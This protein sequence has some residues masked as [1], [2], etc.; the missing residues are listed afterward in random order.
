V[1]HGTHLHI[2][3]KIDSKKLDSKVED[4]ASTYTFVWEKGR[5]KQY[6][7]CCIFNLIM[8]GLDK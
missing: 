5:Q 7:P 2:F 6:S 4:L 3:D 8:A 1:I